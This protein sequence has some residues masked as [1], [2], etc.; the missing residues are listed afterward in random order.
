MNEQQFTAADSIKESIERSKKAHEYISTQSVTQLS[1]TPE[2]IKMLVDSGHLPRELGD[3]FFQRYEEERKRHADMIKLKNDNPNMTPEEFLGHFFKPGELSQ[4]ETVKHY[5]DMSSNIE[6]Y[7]YLLQNRELLETDPVISEKI[8]KTL[9][10]N[11]DS[12]EDMGIVHAVADSL[13]H[14]SKILK[15]M[16]CKHSYE[17]MYV[18]T[19][20]HTN[21]KGEKIT[22][23]Y[24]FRAVSEDDAL[25]ALQEYKNLMLKKGLKTWMAYWCSANE[26]GRIEYKCPLT[27]VMKWSADE[28][29]ESYFSQKEKEEFWYLTKMLGLTKL[30]RSKIK[31]TSKGKQAEEWIEQ[32]LVQIFGGERLLEN[33]DNLP[34]SIA[35]RILMPNMGKKSFAPTLYKISTLKLHPNDIY[36][37]FII[38]TRA[39]QMKRGELA[40]FFDWD[41]LFELG[42][43]QQ[44]AISNSRMAR[45]KIRQKMDK[46]KTGQ[47]IETC[48]EQLIGMSVQPK[49]TKKEKTC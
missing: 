19:G 41:Y 26:L 6:L 14:L 17:N 4:E 20:S 28:E 1:Y 49:K 2:H 39:A 12:S 36:L 16:T 40:L 38:Q 23:E 15:E 27:E 11:F 25:I 34:S 18:A 37:A 22:L 32:P 46:F 21:T 35:V 30:S 47:I 5:N 44:T 43:L 7:M 45:A 24:S 31:R 9:F 10:K 13:Y 29:R 3:W 33:D 8:N 48:E 42:N